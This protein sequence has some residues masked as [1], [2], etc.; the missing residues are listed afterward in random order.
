MDDRYT[1]VALQTKEGFK[2]MPFNVM[3]QYAIQSIIKEHYGKDTYITPNEFKTPASRTKDNVALVKDIFI[4][5]DFHLQGGFTL[6]EAQALLELLTP[7]FNRSIPTP[8][9]VIHSGRGVHFYI[10]IE[11]DKDIAK[12]ELTAK[13]IAKVVDNAVAE[14]NPLINAKLEL[15]KNIGAERLIRAEGSYNTK[16]QTSVTAIY[17]SGAVYDLD[18]LITDFIPE[19]TP[20]KTGGSIKPNDMLNYG[21][22]KRFKGY[23]IEYNAL[24]WL[25]AVLDDL[26]TLQAM[27]NGNVRVGKDKHLTPKYFMGNDGLRNTMLFNFGVACKYAF[28][29]ATTVFESMMAFN[30]GYTRILD[31]VEVEATYKS[32]VTK[33]YRTPK[34]K[35][36]IE[37]LNITADE[38]LQLKTLIGHDEIKRRKRLSDKRYKTKRTIKK[39][40]EKSNLKAQAIMMHSSGMSYRYISKALNISLGSVHNYLK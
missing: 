2:Q 7:S 31:K 39:Q 40:L 12:Y 37:T 4:D 28:N 27:R 30:E 23:S 25:Y 6:G 21:H 15:D 13:A 19:L 10:E 24:T 16:A 38:Q 26:K 18:T 9:K 17:R 33:S 36:L 5:F 22:Y 34:N 35:T 32:V 11:P 8:S 3:D 14:C 29:D 1:F 20:I